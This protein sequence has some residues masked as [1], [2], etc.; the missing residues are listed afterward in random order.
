MTMSQPNTGQDPAQDPAERLKRALN[1][2][3]WDHD[4]LAAYV[5][6]L[7]HRRAEHDIFRRFA[8]RDAGDSEAHSSGNSFITGVASELYAPLDE[9]TKSEVR[10]W[11]HAKAQWEAAQFNDLKERLLKLNR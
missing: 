11:W 9:E 4:F 3:S 5:R 2:V 1:R 6:E 8:F 7:E 10:R